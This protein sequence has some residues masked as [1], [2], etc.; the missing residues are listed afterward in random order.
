VT[1]L[2][3]ALLALLVT[4]TEIAVGDASDGRRYPA[5]PEVRARSECAR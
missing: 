1:K 5:T 4:A 3:F 2:A